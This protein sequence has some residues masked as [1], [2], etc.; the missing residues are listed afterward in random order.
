[1]LNYTGHF[2]SCIFSSVIIKLNSDDFMDFSLKSFPL[3]AFWFKMSKRINM[4]KITKQFIKSS[5]TCELSSVCYIY[6]IIY[7]ENPY[8]CVYMY[9]CM[10]LYMCIY[11]R[12][13]VCF[14]CAYVHTRLGRDTQWDLEKN[15]FRGPTSSLKFPLLI[16]PECNLFVNF[17]IYYT[18]SEFEIQAAPG[19]ILIYR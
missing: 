7:K 18:V 11:S 2:K 15:H 5:N 19:L 13:H 1:M 8:M 16:I 9:M 3:M 10:H 6:L 12:I 17:K 14:V 4:Y